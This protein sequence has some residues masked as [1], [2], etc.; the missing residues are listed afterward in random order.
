M[1]IKNVNQ[2]L[3]KSTVQQSS[4]VQRAKPP[5]NNSVKEEI[6][7]LNEKEK[8]EAIE[9]DQKVLDKSISQANKALKVYNRRIDR[10]IH[11]TTHAMMYKIVDTE[12]KEVIREFP[13][14]KIQ[15]MIAK[16]WELAGLF[17]DEE[18]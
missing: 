16:M 14:K 5:I 15:D 8:R 4:N 2:G 7:R 1:E 10:E 6:H 18:V 17:V 3:D 13:P 9:I 12:T 11:E